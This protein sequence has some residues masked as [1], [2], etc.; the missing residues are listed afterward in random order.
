[1]SDEPPRFMAVIFVGIGVMLAHARYKL[2][3]MGPRERGILTTTPV[4]TL[5]FHKIALIG[6]IRKIVIKLGNSHGDATNSVLQIDNGSF[7]EWIEQM[8]VNNDEITAAAQGSKETAEL[9]NG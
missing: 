2:T 1:M 4:P 3:A 6:A 5:W 7:I 9:I 8:F